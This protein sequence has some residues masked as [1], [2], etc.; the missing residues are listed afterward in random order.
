[1]HYRIA[2]RSQL[3]ASRKDYTLGQPAILRELGVKTS[4][5]GFFFLPTFYVCSSSIFFRVSHLFW[6]V[7]GLSAGEVGEHVQDHD[8]T[9]RLPYRIKEKEGTIGGLPVSL[10]SS[11]EDWTRAL[12]YMITDLKW[13][14]AWAAKYLPPC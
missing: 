9:L 13:I 10:G 14:V 5:T 3:H 1:M 11:L 2:G 8:P 6:C 7:H 4:R 12:K